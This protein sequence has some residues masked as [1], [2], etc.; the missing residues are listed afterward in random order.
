[1]ND[2]K[3]TKRPRKA[4]SGR[5]KGSKSFTR[6]TFSELSS[7]CGSATVVP[8]SRVWLE[9]MGVSIVANKSTEINEIKQEEKS[10]DSIQFKIHR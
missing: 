1:M 8:V 9:Q 7:I 6:M 10:E 3:I 5:K 2:E 4:G